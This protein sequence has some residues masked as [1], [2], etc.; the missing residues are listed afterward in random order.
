[1]ADDSRKNVK[2]DETTFKQLREEKR[3]SETWD[4]FL[5]G[6]VEK[7]PRKADTVRLQSD[8]VQTIA[9]ETA[10]ELEERSKREYGH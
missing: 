8:Q 10:D 5:L 2:I 7:V 1:M 4:E 3:P 6:L 9:R